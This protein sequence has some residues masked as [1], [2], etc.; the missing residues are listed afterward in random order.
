MAVLS[1]P[2]LAKNLLLFELSSVGIFG[3]MRRNCYNT[4]AHFTLLIWS[5]VGQ[6]IHYFSEVI[7]VV[8]TRTINTLLEGK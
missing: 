5:R 7:Q 2:T 8:P 3:D 6:R 1:A 4:F